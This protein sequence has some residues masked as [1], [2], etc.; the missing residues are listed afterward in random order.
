VSR[1]GPSAEEIFLLA[2]ELS[3]GDRPG[4][5]ARECADDGAM[6]AE[7]ESLLR[8]H[9]SAGGFLEQPAPVRLELFAPHE[10]GLPERIGAYEIVRQLGAGG[11]GIVYLAEGGRP[12]RPVALKVLRTGLATASMRRRFELEAEALA[13]LQ[14]P[15]IGQVY[16]AGAARVG[17]V[18]QPYLAMELVE[19]QSLTEYTR[20]RRLGAR[21]RLSMLAEVC[22]A[23]QHAHQRG[24]IHRDLKPGNILVTAEGRPKILDFGVAR[25]ADPSA[26]GANT[27]TGQ[28]I[29][30]LAYMS[31]EQVVGDTG[32]VDARTD[33]YALGV[34]LYELLAGRVPLEV[35]DRAITEAAR[36]I[37]EEEP[38]SLATLDRSLR[39]DVETIVRK[40]MEKDPDRRYQ[41][42]SE[43]ASDIRRFLNE[44][45]IVA[46]PPST[47]YQLRKFARRNKALVVG[48]IAVMVALAGGVVGTS[49][50]LARAIEQERLARAAAEAAHASALA[51]RLEADKASRAKGFLQSILTGADTPAQ[52]IGAGLDLTVREVVTRAALR[53]PTELADAPA[54]AADVYKTIGDTFLLLG[55]YEAAEEHLSLSL[56]AAQRFAP[57]PSTPVSAALTSMAWLEIHRGNAPKGEE[58]MRRALNLPGEILASNAEG[59][60]T[61][62]T[63]LGMAVDAQGRYAEAADIW[64]ES[65]ALAEERLPPDAEERMTAMN[66]IADFLALQGKVDEA[67]EM[68]AVVEETRRRTLGPM[69]PDYMTT[70]QNLAVY[71]SRRFRFTEAKALYERLI[72]SYTRFYGPDHIILA[73]LLGNYGTL[74]RRMDDL[75]GA[76]KVY[77]EALRIARR[78]SGAMYERMPTALQN[79]ASLR[80]EVGDFDEADRLFEE[81]LRLAREMGLPSDEA[82]ILSNLAALRFDQG[83]W[84]EAAEIFRGVREFR[85]GVHGPDAVPTLFAT[86]S[87]GSSLRKLGRYDEALPELER[88]A[89]GIRAAFAQENPQVANAE[90]AYGW[91]LALAGR[92][93][94]AEPMLGAALALVRGWDN[95]NAVLLSSVE[96]A[97]GECMRTLGRLEEADE[98][99]L[100]ALRH[101]R[102]AQG[103]EH[104]SALEVELLVARLRKAQGRDDEARELARR[105]LDLLEARLGEC[106]ATDAARAVVEA[107]TRG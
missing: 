67:A 39:G 71:E 15:G 95:V 42:A 25:V 44:E 27:A 81:A 93:P 98:A 14:H 62:L 54:V 61:M 106:E 4:F 40:A 19:G 22:D 6:R 55:D 47:L 10:P 43:L 48:V 30:T 84:T 11:M 68:L 63:M 26:T 77:R 9:D 60:S 59:H 92:A 17:T 16:E 72:E 70:L 51:A 104:P 12:R 94:E 41:S 82:T 58:V 34:I 50:G 85:A 89:R 36:A 13:R 23:V 28:M 38:T 46:R 31:P 97:Y 53:A 78:K 64:R 32:A 90:A 21:Q 57:E 76:E 101:R 1:T 73:R 3:A 69:H 83:R 79:L 103:A 100:S 86:Q 99:L 20:A 65:L 105:A 8:A 56:E 91:C 2:T 80:H 5:L 66:N 24:V 49:I 74:L 29:G 52:G 102:E 107:V 33:V 18:E 96:S 45:P 88:A 35:S 87:L 37:R 7:I 75:P